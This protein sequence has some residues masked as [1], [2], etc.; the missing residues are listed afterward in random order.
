MGDAAD[1]V[2]GWGLVVVVVVAVSVKGGE[3]CRG[4]AASPGMSSTCEPL[5]LWV[6]FM[7][8]RFWP[9]RGHV[10]L[11]CVGQ[12]CVKQVVGL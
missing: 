5:Q 12:A 1:G 8:I 3:R 6:R 11:L 2:C 10:L 4:K 9:R 7:I